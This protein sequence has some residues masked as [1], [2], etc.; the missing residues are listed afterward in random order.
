[1]PRYVGAGAPIRAS[2]RHHQKPA[3]MPPPP[4]NEG[5]AVAWG[6][7]R[8]AVKKIEHDTAL[9]EDDGAQLGAQRLWRVALTD[10]RRP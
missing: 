4:F 7:H 9:V 5:D 1:M 2:Q 6:Y 8:G 3:L 10:L